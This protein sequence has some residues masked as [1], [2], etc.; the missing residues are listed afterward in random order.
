MQNIARKPIAHLIL[1]LT[2]LLCNIL[3]AEFNLFEPRV[4]G[5]LRQLTADIEKYANSPIMGIG[6][7]KTTTVRV[8][9]TNQVASD[10]CS[11]LCV[12]N[13]L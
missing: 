13:Q 1:G 7:I 6:S 9:V 8:P 3:S 11:V 12:G 4:P 10:P 2:K 5:K